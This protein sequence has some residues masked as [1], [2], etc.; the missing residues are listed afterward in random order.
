MD[1]HV[2]DVAESS[3]RKV[4][5]HVRNVVD[6]SVRSR[7]DDDCNGFDRLGAAATRHAGWRTRAVI[8][9]RLLV[10]HAGLCNDQAKAP[11]ALTVNNATMIARANRRTAQVQHQ[12]FDRAVTAL[13]RQGGIPQYPQGPLQTQGPTR[14]RID[15][16]E[17]VEQP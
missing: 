4:G 3:A 14:R 5:Q 7:G 13:I 6:R 16:A 17:F 1:L 2:Q 10:A 15:K 9:T 12:R 11:G 8:L